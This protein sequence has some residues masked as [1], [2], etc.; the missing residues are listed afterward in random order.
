[1]S[2]TGP[3][4]YDY[5][6]YDVYGQAGVGAGAAAATGAAAAATYPPANQADYQ[7]PQQDY[8]YSSNQGH[9]YPQQ[10]PGVPPVAGAVVAP[11]GLRDGMMARVQVGFNR[12]LEDELGT[13][14]SPTDLFFLATLT[15]PVAIAP[16]QQ[17]WLHTVYDD[18]W[19][20]CE[21]QNQHRGVVPV[22]SLVPWTDDDPNHLSTGMSRSALSLL[23]MRNNI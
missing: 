18:G 20:M 23:S 12:T 8:G 11:M 4:T 16:G 15:N 7:Y 6:T 13:P 3:G 19:A 10:D 1:M 9:D 17:L 2:N 22:T 14:S 5:E 21:D